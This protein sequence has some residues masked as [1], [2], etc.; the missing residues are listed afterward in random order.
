VHDA[1]QPT[2]AIEGGHVIGLS[3]GGRC[4]HCGQHTERIRSHG[5]SCEHFQRKRAG[6]VDPDDQVEH[7][8]RFDGL[9]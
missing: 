4:I 1:T 6:D 5:Y 3:N 7:A 2:V 9:S 8:E